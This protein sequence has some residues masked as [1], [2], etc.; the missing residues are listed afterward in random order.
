MSTLTTPKRQSGFTLVEL[1]IV[2][3]ILAILAA[4][5]IPQFSSATKDT[6]EAALD[7]NLAS[8]RSSLELYKVQHNAWPGSVATS[9]G[10]ACTGGTV[11]AATANTEAAFV[12]SLTRFS[13]KAGNTCT[14]QVG[15]YKFG[16]YIRKAIP[17][18]PIKEINTVAVTATGAAIAPAAATGGWAFDTVSGQLVV[19]SN[20]LDSKGVAYSLR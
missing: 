14:V 2:V 10:A 11:G 19:N 1:L 12:E 3:I 15:T 6:Q 18:D 5:V 13:D 16:P 17:T 9:A 20:A 8:L 4:I 7:T